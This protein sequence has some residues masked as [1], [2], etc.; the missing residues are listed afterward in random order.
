MAVRNFD[1]IDDQ[2]TLSTGALASV[3]GGPITVAAIVKLAAVDGA[4]FWAGSTSAQADRRFAVEASTTWFYD[5]SSGNFQSLFGA[6][7]AENWTVIAATKADGTSTP[8]GHKYVFGTGVWSHVNAAG[9]LV[10][11][12]SGPG[13]GG[14]LL[15]SGGGTSVVLSG[16][17]AVVGVWTSALSDGEI[18]RLNRSLQAWRDLLPAALWRLDQAAVTPLVDL[19]GG[20]AN[21]TAIVGTNVVVGD[22]PPGFAFE[23][24]GIT[25]PSPAWFI[26]RGLWRP[27]MGTDTVP[28]APAGEPTYVPA[29]E[30][31]YGGFY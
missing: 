6:S 10:D 23:P 29:L 12:G 27:W 7:T 2:I 18:E 16:R 11:A 19:T 26:Q 3:D 17:L 28:A 5:T 21:E 13:A 30:S 8:R 22:D 9:T 25:P 1:G 4:V 15:L 14:V 31:Q 20:G 24:P